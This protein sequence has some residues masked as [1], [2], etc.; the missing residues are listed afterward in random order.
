MISVGFEAFDCDQFEE[1]GEQRLIK[2]VVGPIRIIEIL[3][4]DGC[5]EH[6]IFSGCS[7]HFNC[8]NVNCIYS[9][10]SRNERKKEK[11]ATHKY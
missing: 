11:A 3:R 6:M 10:A 4:Q 9:R 8:Q 5:T 2:V 7:S 1:D